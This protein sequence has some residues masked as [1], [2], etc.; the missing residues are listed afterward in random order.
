MS[1]SAPRLPQEAVRPWPLPPAR[2]PRT[3][4]ELGY[5]FG[6]HLGRNSSNWPQSSERSGNQARRMNTAK[7][8]IQLKGN[9][10]VRFALFCRSWL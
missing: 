2:A 8:G 9:P 6:A 3:R 1:T 10:T 5:H 7:I 4:T